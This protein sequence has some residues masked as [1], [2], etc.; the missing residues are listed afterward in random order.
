MIRCIVIDD[1]RLAR[2]ELI[3]MLSD[4]S[5]LQIVAESGNPEEALNLIN[6]LNPDLIFLDIQMPGMDGFELLQNIDA[7]P[8]VIFVTAYDEYALKAF[9]VNALSYLIKPVEKS[10]LDHLV[11]NKLVKLVGSN[12][13]KT[14][15]TQNL[16]SLDDKVFVKDGDRCWFVALKEI[17][18]F[19]SEGNY[20]RLYFSDEK[21]LIHKTLNS[22]E[23]K[24]NPTQF[25]RINRKHIINLQYVDKIESWFSGTLLIKTISG[26]ELELS[27]RQSAKFREI[28]SL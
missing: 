3:S 1:E 11:Q 8:E 17:E 21:P 28:M 27:R 12:Q 14:T 16:L 25:F 9:Q 15:N 24:L 26:K 2:K 18:L 7:A 20:V 19:E 5:E 6:N 4:Y 23:E 10:T 13:N 22:L